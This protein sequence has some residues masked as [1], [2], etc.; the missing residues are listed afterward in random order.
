[1]VKLLVSFIFQLLIRG[2]IQLSCCYFQLDD[3]KVLKRNHIGKH[4]LLSTSFDCVFEW[5]ITERY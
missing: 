3:H 4:K 5:L 2:A 1:M